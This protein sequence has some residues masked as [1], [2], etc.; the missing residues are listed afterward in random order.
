MGTFG[1]FVGCAGAVVSAAVRSGD[2]VVGVA[3]AVIKTVGNH[4]V[5]EILLAVDRGL[6]AVVATAVPFVDSLLT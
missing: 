6:P 2:V 1:L 4:A 3:E 5:W